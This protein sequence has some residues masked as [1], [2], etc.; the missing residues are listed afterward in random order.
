MIISC[1]NC[2]KKF[3]INYIEKY[4]INKNKSLKDLLMDQKFV[5]GI[6]NIYVNEILFLS[7]LNPYKNVQK[8][9]L[10]DFKT[11]IKFTR[12]ILKK[13]IKQGG[14]SIKNFND[15]NGK[16]GHFQQNFRVY[17]KEGVKCHKG[18]CKGV[19]KRSFISNR[20]TFFCSRCHK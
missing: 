20:S 6:G 13:S 3:N 9:R 8:T 14:S 19:I 15:S 7:R 1:I 11:I 16:Q 17:G 4:V 2:T 18:K 12:K 10:V 5:S